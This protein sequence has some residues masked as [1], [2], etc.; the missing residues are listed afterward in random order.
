MSRRGAIVLAVVFLIAFGLLGLGKY[1][2]G[3]I[4]TLQSLENAEA[5]IRR[6]YPRVDQISPDTLLLHR[7]AGE[8]VLLIDARTEEEFA[9]SHLPGSFNKETF[10]ETFAY[11]EQLPSPPDVIVLYGAIG[12]RSSKLAEQLQSAQS[13]GVKH[14]K[15][16]I[17]RWAQEGRAMVDEEGSEVLLVHPYNR[18]WAHLLDEDNRASITPEE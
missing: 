14:L 1:G 18:H 10:D 4:E 16:S 11:L 5:D 8:K 3:K 2:Y 7:K 15:G 9:M 6:K 12:Y 17:F 13:I